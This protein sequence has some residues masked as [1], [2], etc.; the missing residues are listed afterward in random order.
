MQTNE[1]TLIES[2]D[3]LTSAWPQDRRTW[4]VQTEKPEIGL[5]LGRWQSLTLTIWGVN[6]YLRVYLVPVEHVDAVLKAT[7]LPARKKAPGRVREGV[8]HRHNLCPGP[9]RNVQISL[10]QFSKEGVGEQFDAD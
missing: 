7:G 5:R 1:N 10:G 4:R 8:S 3:G 2:D 9:L 6:C